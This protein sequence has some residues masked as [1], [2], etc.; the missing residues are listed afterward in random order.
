M[1]EMG[2]RGSLPVSGGVSLRY[3]G[4]E[5]PTENAAL[6]F[7][8]GYHENFLKYGELFYDMKAD[9]LSI[10]ACDMRG[11]GFSDHLLPDPQV[12]Y[13][14]RWERY[15]EDL[16]AFMDTVVLARPHR[17]LFILAHSMGGAITTLYLARHQTPVTG[18]ILCSPLMRN[19][20]PPVARLTVQTL[21]L[22]GKG[23]D[24]IP[25]GKPYA[26]TAFE[27]NK[28]THSQA[29]HLIKMRMNEAY[30]QVCLGDP[31]NHFVVQMMKLAAAARASASSLALPVLVFKAGEDAYVDT[32]AV[33]ELCAV[34]PKARK[35]TFEGARHEILIETD[36][37]RDRALAEIRGFLASC[38][39]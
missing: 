6:V 38:N 28:E 9:G 2:V 25:G 21:D 24:R 30:P 16:A 34:A 15:I 37:I 31:S 39:T 3:M 14:E 13:V 19:L 23:R 26:S 10:Y 1:E 11:Q 35:V 8:C 22:L 5:S 12:A 20:I 27:E 33:D 36:D 17:R 4:I 32:R 29:R 7:V 18:A